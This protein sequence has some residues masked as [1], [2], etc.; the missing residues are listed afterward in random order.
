MRNGSSRAYAIPFRS[1]SERMGASPGTTA[2]ASRSQ[3]ATAELSHWPYEGLKARVNYLSSPVPL[4]FIY[5]VDMTEYD[6][7]PDAYERHLATQEKIARWVDETL[8][9]SPC[10]PFA[11]LPS[12]EYERSQTPQP[13][14]RATPQG[15]ISP[16]YSNHSRRQE[17][18]QW[19]NPSQQSSTSSASFMMPQ[20]RPHFG[21]SVTSPPPHASAGQYFHQVSKPYPSY[22]PQYAPA[23]SRSGVTVPSPFSQRHS[24]QHQPP[25]MPHR[26]NSQNSFHSLHTPHVYSSPIIQPQHGSGPY[27]Y[28]SP[29]HQHQQA[30]NHHQ[31]HVVVLTGD[32]DFTVVQPPGHHIQYVVR[33]KKNYSLFVLIH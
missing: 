6:Y 9:Q 24:S 3:H 11:L 1:F 28:Y 8:E 22:P 30:A 25:P 10:N 15:D 18:N 29:S 31:Q 2:R 14:F 13:A 19:H 12:E 23:P 27:P 16:T 4:C 17:H 5:Y 21:R 26:S 7:S 32:R 33:F 20:E